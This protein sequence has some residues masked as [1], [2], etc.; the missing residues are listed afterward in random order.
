MTLARV[1]LAS[2][3]DIEL[4]NLEIFSS[5]GG[6]LEGYPCAPINDRLLAGLAERR[7]STYRSQPVHLITPPRSYPEVGWT[8]LAFGPVEQLPAVYCRASFRSGCTDEEL[9]DVLHRS[10]LTVV[11]FQDDLARPVAE[12]VT[13]AVTGL[14]WEELAEDYEL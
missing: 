1:T 9:D 5:Y 12:F 4:S 2:G 8:R 11:W 13:A 3:R 7:E 6:M 14:A 10:W